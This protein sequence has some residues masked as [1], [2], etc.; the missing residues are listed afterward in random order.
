M[1]HPGRKRRSS[2]SANG[3]PHSQSYGFEYRV[4]VVDYGDPDECFHW[5]RRE[6]AERLQAI[7]V[8]D[9]LRHFN[10]SRARN[11]GAV[12]ARAPI[13]AFV[14]ADTLLHEDWLATVVEL[15]RE[16]GTTVVCSSQDLV[17]L[18]GICAVRS[19]VF[20]AV[21]GYDEGMTGWGFEDNDLNQISREVLLS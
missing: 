10:L 21:R 20:H 9:N 5:C 3:A 17:G 15:I 4:I 8:N 2:G 13:L 1:S 16:P 6:G 12:Y 7:R 18:R 14:D 19:S 11:C